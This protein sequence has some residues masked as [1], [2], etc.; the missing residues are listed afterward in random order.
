MPTKKTPV[1]TCIVLLLYCCLGYVSALKAQERH[2]YLANDNHTDYFWSGSPQDYDN[3]ALNEINYYLAQADAT[4]NLASPYQC[5]YNLDGAWYVYSYKQQSTPEQFENLMS[6]IRSGHISMPYN[7]FVSTY[8][9]QP[10]EAIL[11]GMYWPGRLEREHNLDISLAVSMENQAL[12]LGLSSLWAGAGARYSW[13][14]VCGCASPVANNLLGNREHEIYNYQGPDGSGVLMKWYS[15]SPNGNRRLGGYAEAA[16][17]Y[18]A[19]TDCQA[20]SNTPDYPYA[21]TGAFGSGWDDLEY[22][23]STF[24]QAAQNGSNGDQQVYVSN[25]SDFFEH[26]LSAYDASSLPVESVTHGNDWDTDCEAL[27]SVT[28]KVRR[29]VEKLRTAEALASV[30]SL[31]DEGLYGSLDAQ[32]EAAWVALGSYWEHNFG[33]GGCCSS[34]RGPWEQGLEEQ[35]SGYVD[36]LNERSLKALAGMI[37]N[38]ASDQRFMVFNPL[39]WA[40]TDYVDV[41]YN[42]GAGIKAVDLQTGQE[43]PFQLY[44]SQGSTY[45]RIL[46][47]DV[48]SVGYK[49]YE[50]RQEAGTSFPEAATWNG[51]VFENSFYRLTVTSQGVITSLLD[52]MNGNQE[53]VQET[54]GRYVNDFGQGNAEGGMVE[55]LHSGPV[56]ATIACTSPNPLQHTTYI[57]LYADINRIDIDN[58]INDSFGNNI[59][60]YSFS[61]DLDNPTVWHEELGAVLKAKYITDGGHYAAPDQAVR[62]EWQTLNHFADIGNDN[63]GVVLS[64]L[65]A[66]FMKLGNSLVNILD[67][68]SAQVNVLIGGRMAGSGPGFADQ[69]GLT[70]FQNNFAL[71][72]RQGAFDAARSMKFALEHQNGLVGKMLDNQAGT[73]PDTSFSLLSMSA[74]GVLLWGVK[75][76]EEGITDG[77]LILRLW[78]LDNQSESNTV[79]FA[80]NALEAKRT[81]HLETDIEPATVSQGALQST[82]G[83]QKMETYRVFLDTTS[84]GCSLQSTVSQSICS[85]ESYEGYT[86]TG[87][88]TDTYAGANGC[89]STRVLN[90]TVLPV[91]GTMT[92][93]T[94]CAGESYE[95][96]TEAGQYTDTYTG[97]NG[98]DSVHVLNLTVLPTPIETLNLSICEGE[99][100]EGYT[101]TGMYT[102][103]YVSTNGCDSTRVLNLSV[104]LPSASSI[105]AS[106][107]MG[108]S[109]EGYTQ[110][111]VYTD[112]FTAANGCD[113][114]RTLTLEVLPAFFTL[115]NRIICEGEAYEGYTE[116]GMYKDTLVAANGCDSIRTLYLFVVPDIDTVMIALPSCDSTELG[117]SV[118]T[119]AS[120]DGCDSTTVTTVYYSLVEPNLV[121]QPATND[122]ENGSAS[123]SP[124]GGVEPY[125]IQWSN[126]GTGASVSGLAPGDYSVTVTAANGCNTVLGFEVSSITG[127]SEAIPSLSSFEV[128]PNPAT[129]LLQVDVRFNRLEEGIF[130]LQDYLG[131]QIF[132]D[133]FHS[134][135]YHSEINVKKLGTG[136]YQVRIVLGNREISKPVVVQ[137]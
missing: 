3:V 43:A 106:I 20:K 83:Q 100:Y 22:L 16:S 38:N 99:N 108:T 86:E 79:S 103:T 30:V 104:L 48:P 17:P 37:S 132:R 74:P 54:D 94:I 95:G 116:T 133:N 91:A 51:N 49:V 45:L 19:I 53:L 35:I 29:S 72:S 60:T 39:G 119:L 120:Q 89:D 131:R 85:G 66:G 36:S 7:F 96:Y 18:T 129:D 58:R 23:S 56:S 21:I 98:C 93:I 4:E 122:D 68:N 71:R 13:K 84:T 130:I 14:G 70:D 126:G 47:Q 28:G 5:R 12:P 105:S 11:R 61:F 78:N 124:S 97:A 77:G 87:V 10:T 33:L 101:E 114:T 15:L 125:I 134:F 117:V 107:C 32:R 69:F 50:I 135:N 34:E 63:S 25:E 52:K 136:V 137:R 6:H 118:V 127:L 111:G 44:S 121:V 42:G 65:G 90:L 62:F 55:V 64:N 9:G 112:V 41:P 76:A 73:M 92:A 59:R 24:V 123:V 82:I 46:A 2:I 81:T 80:S 57:T 128:Y 40:R 113:S 88:Y 109:F 1:F 31:A 110:S 115:T 26:F 67:E 27:A 8:G 102:D 75:P